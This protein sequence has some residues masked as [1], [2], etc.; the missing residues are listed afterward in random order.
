MASLES[1]RFAQAQETAAAP[2]PEIAVRGA[3]RRLDALCEEAPTRAQWDCREG[4]GACCRLQ[5]FVHPHEADAIVTALRE[6]YAAHE[7]A[8]L[9][10]RVAETA[11]A[12]AALDPGGW[13]RARLM[14][15][16]LDERE[17]CRIYA[18]RPLKCRAHASREVAACEDVTAS[19]PL[20]DW[21]VKAAE[22]V[23][24]GLGDTAPREELHAAVAARL[25]SQAVPR[26]DYG[27][28][29]ST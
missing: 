26:R 16:F 22:A 2:S 14:C 25:D 18:F 29:S 5:V 10:R 28:G 12:G 7:L 19:V 20:D 21:L 1:I 11:E 4:C 6:R 17:R 8:A 13:R 9:T 24:H 23:L 27:A 15:A 3:W